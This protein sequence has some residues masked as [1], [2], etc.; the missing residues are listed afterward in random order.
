MKKLFFLV[1]VFAGFLACENEIIQEQ[2]QD[3]SVTEDMNA[4]QSGKIDV[5]H[6]D[7]ENDSW[8]VINIS[9]NA[10]GGHEKHGDVML[11]DEDGDG[12]VTL[13]NECVPGGDCDDTNPDQYPGAEEPQWW[14]FIGVD[15]D[16]D[17]SITFDE[18]FGD[19]KPSGYLNE[20]DAIA[21]L[22][23]LGFP[24]LGDCDDT[25]PDVYPGAPEICDDVDNDCD[26]YLLLR[27][28]SA[29]FDGIEIASGIARFG[30]AGT[31][32]GDW[33]D[34]NGTGCDPIA[35][36]LTGK[37]AIIDR[38]ACFFEQKVLNAE[39]Q[40]AIGVIICNYEDTFLPAAML[41]PEPPLG[42]SIPSIII[43]Y[44]DCEFI[45]NSGVTSISFTVEDTCVDNDVRMSNK[46]S[47]NNISRRSLESTISMDS[48]K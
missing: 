20:E 38:G 31:V 26:G 4:R 22:A 32:T 34:T 36:D 46:K 10:W 42:A 48:S 8:H 41:A 3:A 35:E 6:Y 43:Q 12:W 39:L 47:K 37:I 27:S 7:A 25:N 11:I 18:I 2:P 5:C 21:A 14:Y 1:L 23:A 28:S 40:G 44:D 17:G 30:G 16:G 29:T 9:A 13:E 33:V 15:N 19:C 24:I 45:K